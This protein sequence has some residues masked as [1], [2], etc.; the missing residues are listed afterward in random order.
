[1]NALE[2]LGAFNDCFVPVWGMEIE[3][4]NTSANSANLECPPLFFFS[5]SIQFNG[6]KKLPSPD[7][8]RFGRNSPRKKARLPNFFGQKSNIMNKHPAPTCILTT[9][10][11]QSQSGGSK[12]SV[13]D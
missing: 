12:Y 11:H 7:L 4:Y 6:W 2:G 13:A 9:A 10:N 5:F 8:E 3:C 1:M